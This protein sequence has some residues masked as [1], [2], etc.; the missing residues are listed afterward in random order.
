MP[1]FKL[2]NLQ[3]ISSAP[4]DDEANWLVDAEG[5]IDFLRANAENEDIV[6]FASTKCAVIH[7]AL[8]L[9]D[10]L[11]P[12]AICNAQHERFPQLDDGWK[13]QQAWGGGQGHRMYLEAPLEFSSK[14]FVGGEQ[15]VFRRVFYDVE[16]VEPAFEMSQKLIHSLDLHFLPD[17]Q[18]YCRLDSRGDIEEVIKV[19]DHKGGGDW[20][21]F[22]VVTIRRRDLDKYMALSNTCLVF[23]FD[24]TRVRWGNFGGWGTIDRY[25]REFDDL[26]YHGGVDGHGSYC[27]G[28]M[29]VRPSVTVDDLIQEWKEE[30]DVSK[31]QY[32][33]FKIYDRKND[34][35]VETSCGPEFLSNYFQ[36]SELPWEISPAFFRPEVLQRFKNDPE[37]YSLEDRSISCRNA[38]YLKTYDIN[39]VGQVHTYIGYLADLPYEEQLYW[40]SF[41]EWPKGPISRRALKTDIFGQWDTD[42]EPLSELKRI[43]VKLDENPPSWWNKRGKKLI[44][45]VRYPVTDSSKE[46]ADELLALDQLVVEG[47]LVKPLRKLIEKRGGKYDRNWAS[48]RVLREVLVCYGCDEDVASEI[49]HPLLQV[50]GLRTDVRGHATNEKKRDAESRAR[51]EFGT[52]REHFRQLA[53]ECEDCL[54]ELVSALS[55]FEEIEE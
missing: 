22:R 40:Q 33:T 14:V 35:A 31:R 25:E 2:T 36:K 26:S 46:W 5:S 30:D 20:D 23:R 51:S 45:S 8:A 9:T 42:Y 6:L 28:T 18:A 10:Q 12:E 53:A 52:F 47:F 32:A 38:W 27:A 44:E 29:V 37:K 7:G 39:E 43:V 17:R 19:V 50:H 16:E 11:T 54:S 4:R 13:I 15:L 49:I 1:T 3:A 34:K 48:L 21:W 55:S 24:F 41:N